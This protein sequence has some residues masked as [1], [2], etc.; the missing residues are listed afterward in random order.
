MTDMAK[1][2]VKNIEKL[3]PGVIKNIL[4]KNY[5]TF[6]I[7]GRAKYFLVA[8]NKENLISAIEAAK[9]VGLPFFILAG[10]SNILV[11]D[12]GFDGIVIKMQNTK[13]EIRNTKI[14]T[15]AGALLSYLAGS[16]FRAGLAGLE[17]AAGIPGTIGGAVRGNAGAF[18]GSI[19]DR[20]EEVEIY[21]AKNERFRILKNKDC[22]F[23][24]RDSIFKKD[25]NLIII[26]AVLKLKKGNKK[27][28]AKKMKRCLNYRKKHQPLSFPSCGSVFVNPSDSSARELISKCGLRGKKIGQAQISEKHANFIVNLGKARASDVEKLINLAKK[29]VKQ[30]FGISLKEEIEYLG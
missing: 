21:D 26:S 13:Y 9:K 20:V 30:K 22:L 8:E 27:E 18:G 19:A 1:P 2:R 7:G 24:Y 5:T 28:I 12:K 25:K 29:K 11:S 6:K 3:L 17:W 16:S 10:G 14:K 15:G 23:A 4:L